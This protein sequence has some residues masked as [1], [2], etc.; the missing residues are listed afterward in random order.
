MALLRRGIPLLRSASRNMATEVSVAA[1]SPFLRFGNPAPTSLDLTPLLSSIPETEVG[2]LFCRFVESGA[3]TPVDRLEQGAVLRCKTRA[4]GRASGGD[5]RAA[6]TRPVAASSS[7][8]AHACR[9]CPWRAREGDS[10]ARARA[11][12]R[13]AP[14]SRR[15]SARRR[16]KKKKYSN[17]RPRAAPPPP[18]KK[19]P[20]QQ[21]LQLVQV[22][23]LGNGMRVATEAIPYAET[24]TVGVWINA[25][26]RFETDANNGTAH[27][28]EH[29]LFKG[30]RAR[31]TRDLEV[32]IENM[33]GSLN[34]YTGREQTCYFARVMKKDAGKAVAILSDILLNS[35]L[36][37]R[38]VERERDVI[39]REMEE[40]NKQT[41]ELV[42]DHLHATAF[43]FTPLGRTILGPE[44]NIRAI[45]RA[46]L[47]DYMATHYR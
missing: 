17:T 38:A 14:L 33:G 35:R 39:L 15:L 12:R 26:S 4:R 6:L 16:G 5:R 25:G 20:T 8:R 45:T 29:L 21:Q 2:R 23:T 9:C 13:A 11:R 22:T 41:S 32:E 34:A 30:T 18:P 27:F 3:Q 19:T 44:R 28:L 37:E 36:D 10:D 47:A 7:P 43:Q 31:T 1:E 24:A 40:V 46:D 42:F